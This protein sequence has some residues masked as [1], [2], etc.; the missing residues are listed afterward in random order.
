MTGSTEAE[1][2]RGEKRKTSRGT[3]SQRLDEKKNL[4]L[5]AI[6]QL[7]PGRLIAWV[8]VEHD[9]GEKSSHGSI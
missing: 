2:I 8:M 4:G 9:H 5:V 1:V 3:S 6:L 7:I